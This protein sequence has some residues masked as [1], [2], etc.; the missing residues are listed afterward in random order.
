MGP[1]IQDATESKS[2]VRKVRSSKFEELLQAV[3]LLQTYCV[4]MESAFFDCVPQ[5]AEHLLPLLDS[6]DEVSMLCDEAL[7]SV[8]V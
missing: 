8:Y 3:Q 4:E 7:V 6:T 2:A 1:G 5:V